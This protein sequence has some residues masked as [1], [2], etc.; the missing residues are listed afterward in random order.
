[1][2]QNQNQLSLVI[3]ANGHLGNNLVRMLLEQ[4][5]NVRATVRNYLDREKALHLLNCEVVQAD[6]MDKASLVE[7]MKGIDVL[8]MPAAVYKHWAKDPKKEII[9]VNTEGTKNVL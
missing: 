1:M 9:Q 2:K 5:A 3:G 4:K 7:S 6:L 8:Y